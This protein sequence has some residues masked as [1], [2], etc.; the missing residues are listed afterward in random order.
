MRVNREE[1]VALLDQRAVLEVNGNN[2]AGNVWPDVDVVDGFEAPRIAL[3]V[4][5]GLRENGSDVNL[6][7][8]RRCVSG[9]SCTQRT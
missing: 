5:D 8:R 2:G 1:G 7:S 3:P 6:G 4:C 9:L